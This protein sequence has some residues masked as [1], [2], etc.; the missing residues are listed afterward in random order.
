MRLH[1]KTQPTV[2]SSDQTLNLPAKIHVTIGQEG[3]QKLLSQS[4]CVTCW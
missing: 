1:E 2:G 4:K 3:R